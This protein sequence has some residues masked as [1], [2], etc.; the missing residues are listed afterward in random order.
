MLLIPNPQRIRLALNGHREA[1]EFP[2]EE[3]YIVDLDQPEA[4]TEEQDT[5]AGTEIASS[6]FREVS[7]SPDNS[8]FT[9]DSSFSGATLPTPP[10]V[11]VSSHAP[12]FPVQVASADPTASFGYRSL[13]TKSL[14]EREKAAVTVTPT[15]VLVD[16]TPT[17]PLDI[18]VPEPEQAELPVKVAGLAPPRHDSPAPTVLE[19]LTPVAPVQEAS[20]APNP[21]PFPEVDAPSAPSL[22]VSA[23]PASASPPVAA[24]ATPVKKTPVE[25]STDLSMSIIASE[26]PQR[27]NFRFHDSPL[28]SV[29]KVLAEYQGYTVILDQELAGR[30]SGEF[31]NAEPAQVFAILVKTH[32]CR[33]SRRGNVLL[34]TVR[35]PEISR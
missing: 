29:F 28:P 1:K 33:V 25:L 14:S 4:E 30:Y 20:T 18:P 13:P 12:T 23:P 3:T 17:A 26:D 15:P 31:V 21:A 35:A 2:F 24:S 32:N 8:N 10:A 11:S 34:L 5:L 6:G 19:P 22:E 7:N 27:W 16:K 9:E